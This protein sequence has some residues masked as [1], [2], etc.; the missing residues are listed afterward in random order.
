MTAPAPPPVILASASPIRAAL[1]RRAGITVTVETAAVDEAEIKAAFA[2][3]R[4]DA[5]ECA[6]ALA[7]A[8]AARVARRQPGA[9]VIGA[10]QMLVCDGTWFDKPEDIAAAR[11]QLTQL[12]GRRHELVSAVAV[13]RG[14]ECLWRHVERPSLTMRPFSDAFLDTYLA[15]A[16]DALT[17]SVGAYRLE[18]AGI[19][20]FSRID[21]DYFAILGLPLLP[22]LAFLREHGVVGQ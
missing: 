5:A 3:E 21:G 15:T 11:L 13:L 12:R 7:E 8:K 20:L 9:L 1:L 2:A 6:A 19:Q 14:G 17:G 10:D 22:L 18:E 16:G 4:R